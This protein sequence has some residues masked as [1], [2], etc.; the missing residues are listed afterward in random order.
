MQDESCG[1]H[2]S[3]TVP[4][5]LHGN[6][7]GSTATIS[8]VRKRCAFCDKKY[9]KRN[10]R[11]SNCKTPYCSNFREE[12]ERQDEK[13]CRLAAQQ[14]NLMLRNNAQQDWARTFPDALPLA[15]WSPKRW[16]LNYLSS[17]IK[18]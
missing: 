11:C 5:S 4:Q 16:I 14:L 3:E 17:T 12:E 7:D 15:K 18:R 8:G 13:G 9:I 2:F 10:I 6:N 1:K